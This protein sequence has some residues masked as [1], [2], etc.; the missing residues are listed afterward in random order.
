MFPDLLVLV[1][2]EPTQGQ[3][4]RTAYVGAVGI[5]AAA[6]ILGEERTGAFGMRVRFGQERRMRAPN[7]L[8]F[9]LADA[10]AIDA[11][12]GAAAC[13]LEPIGVFGA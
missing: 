3:P 6:V 12:R 9:D 11:T 13:A 8:R 1:F 2:I 10:Q 4:L 7:A 5:D